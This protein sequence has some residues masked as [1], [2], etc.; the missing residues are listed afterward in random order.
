MKNSILKKIIL[1]ATAVAVPFLLIAV[2]LII[3]M[4]NYNRTYE[5]IVSNMTT[6]NDYNLSFKEAMDESLYK[7]VVG[8]AAF[9]NISEEDAIRNPY[10]L[11][12]ELRSEF[13]RLKN[14]TKEPESRVWI[15]SLFRNTDTLEKRVNDIVKNINEGGRYD[16]NIKELDDNIYMLTDLIQD[17]IQYYIYYQTKDMEQVSENLSA[18][19]RTLFVVS[20]VA[21]IL[22]IIFAATATCYIAGK[23]LHPVRDLG[24]AT[25]KV[26]SGD[27]SVRANTDSGDEIAAL[28]RRFNEMTEKLQLLV[29]KVKED[30]QKIRRTDLRLLQEQINPHFLYNTLDTII[31]LMESDKVDEAVEM[32]V[33]LSNFFRL[34]L[35]KGK[36]MITLREEMQHIRSYLEIQEVRYRDIMEYKIH[37]DPMLENFQILKLTI[38][39]IV[40]NA[41]YHGLKIKRAKG[42]IFINVQ[43]KE[44]LLYLTVEDNGVGMEPEELRQLREEIRRPCEERDKGFGLA[45]VNERIRMYF[46]EQYGMTIE[47]EKGKGTIIQ[48]VLPAILKENDQNVME[49]SEE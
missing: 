2:F 32:V 5:N 14:V 1:L 20:G 16:E 19:M 6:A 24:A 4:V 13:T 23:I 17:D 33:T 37:L 9:D 7:I 45:N 28:S 44:E 43:K 47:S 34:T 38:Q 27:F 39:P 10:D 30:Q 21:L 25:E 35:S 49:E 3:S 40:E 18:Q 8:Y 11:M 42:H 22:L 36:E 29:D 12:K 48:I 31:W 41:L 26:A 46:G 15:E